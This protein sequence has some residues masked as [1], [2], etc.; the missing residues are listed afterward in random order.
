MKY[1]KATNYALHTMVYL[2]TLPKGSTI[3]VQ[4]LAEMQNLSPTYLSKILTKL[5]KGGLV[6]STPGAKGG[7]KVSKPKDEISFL[8]VIKTVEGDSN[9]FHCSMDQNEGCMI[10]NVMTE[11]EQNMKDDLDHKF[12]IDI[13]NKMEEMLLPIE[14]EEQ[15]KKE[16]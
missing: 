9:L 15:I 16:N 1:S 10:E 5:A 6:E 3:G 14:K 11:A 7:Y 8:D 13:A 2:V 12:I 4:R